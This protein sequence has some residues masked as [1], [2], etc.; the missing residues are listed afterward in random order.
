MR[1]FLLQFWENSAVRREYRL[2]PRSKLVIN[3]SDEQEA[4][5]KASDYVKLLISLEVSPR[6]WAVDE[7]VGGV[8]VA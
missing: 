7:V 4:R 1:M 3:A 8:Y 5:K 6:D 2:W